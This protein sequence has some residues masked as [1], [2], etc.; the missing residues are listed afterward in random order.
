MGKSTDSTLAHSP[1]SKYLVLLMFDFEYKL[2]EKKSIATNDLTSR[3]RPI[4]YTSIFNHFMDIRH[5]FEGTRDF[6]GTVNY[7][8]C[9]EYYFKGT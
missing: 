7:I 9:T 1:F 4:H 3:V 5:Y 2:N 8:K 6:K